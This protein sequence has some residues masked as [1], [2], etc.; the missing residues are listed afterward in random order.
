MATRFIPDPTTIFGV[1]LHNGDR[2]YLTDL[3]VCLARDNY[4]V[5]AKKV[6]DTFASPKVFHIHDPAGVSFEP[7][8]PDVLKALGVKPVEDEPVVKKTWP[9]TVTP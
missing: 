2:S 3:F 9:Y 6:N 5:V 1:R 4:R 7:V 8:S